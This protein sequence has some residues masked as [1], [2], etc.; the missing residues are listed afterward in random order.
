MKAL[1]KAILAGALTIVSMTLGAQASAEEVTVVGTG[2][3]AIIIEKL[4]TAFA[5]NNPGVTV[6]VPPSIGS[7]GGIKAVGTDQAAVGRIAR[8]LKETEK[9]Y[10]LT[11]TPILKLPIVFF[12][13]KSL[14]VNAL[15]AQQACDIYSGKITNWKEVGGPDA[16]IRVIRREDGDSSLDVLLKSLPGFKDIT[17]TSKCKTT[18]SDPETCEM[19]QAKEHTIAFGTYANAKEVDATI[20]AIDGK[21]PTDI[22]YPYV[23][24]LALVYKE[25]NKTGNIGKFIEFVTSAPAQEI[26]LKAGGFSL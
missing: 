1:R 12:A 11:Y 25:K 5:Q 15:T 26:I 23:G 14:G 3:G 22:S 17:I 13:H 2:S 4:G 21:S 8:G 19:V 16:D 20:L 10:G 24:T 9:E 7:G 6:E 18:L